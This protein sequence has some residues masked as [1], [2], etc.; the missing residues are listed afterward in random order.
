MCISGLKCGK[1][2]LFGNTDLKNSSNTWRKYPKYVSFKPASRVCFAAH[3]LPLSYTLL[4][5]SR[6]EKKKTGLLIREQREMAEC[7]RES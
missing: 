3:V 7:T 1:D 4:L 2:Y 5:F 6:Q